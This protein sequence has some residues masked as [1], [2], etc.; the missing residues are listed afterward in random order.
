MFTDWHK[1]QVLITEITNIVTQ[2]G[3][4]VDS[5]IQLIENFNS[6]SKIAIKIDKLLNK[7]WGNIEM[8]KDKK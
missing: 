3:C 5:A 7:D 2:K 6:Q 8:S 1:E 4:A